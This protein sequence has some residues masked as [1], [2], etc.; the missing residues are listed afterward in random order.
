M[1]NPKG[2]ASS[3]FSGNGYIITETGFPR[4]TM[5]PFTINCWV[6]P[7]GG[8]NWYDYMTYRVVNYAGNTVDCRMEVYNNGANIG[9][10]GPFPSMQGIAT[11]KGQWYMMT[12]THDGAGNLKAY[13]NGTQV[14]SVTC[15]GES[16]LNWSPTGWF[17][18]GD[19]AIDF[20][21]ADYRV[22]ATCLSVDDIKSLYQTGA[23][24]TKNGAFMTGQLV[25]E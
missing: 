15:S 10:Y 4:G 20:K 25:E 8:V 11:T 18:V 16:Q 2:L 17:R 6:N 7:Q 9:F 3:Q 21:G 23:S 12:L 13:Q 5:Q 22:Y 19:G 14:G 1:G 24:I